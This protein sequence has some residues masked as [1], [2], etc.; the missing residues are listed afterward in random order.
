[1]ELLQDF[2][3]RRLVGSQQR[4]VCV[5]AH[6]GG[7]I[8][9]ADFKNELHTTDMFDPRLLAIVVKVVDVSYGGENGFSQVAAIRGAIFTCLV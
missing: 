6:Y 3:H 2:G 9:S 1:M 4:L 7:T 5:V 8:G